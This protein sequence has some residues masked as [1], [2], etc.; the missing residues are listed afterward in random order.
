MHSL[1]WLLLA[2][3]SYSLVRLGFLRDFQKT[4]QRLGISERRAFEIY[5][6]FMFPGVL[7][8]ES[9]HWITAKALRI[10]TGSVSLRPQH[11]PK[12]ISRL[13]YVEVSM[14]DPIRSFLVG[15]APLVIGLSVIYL[16][17]EYG[18]GISEGVSLFQ[19]HHTS[20][21]A[22]WLTTRI[23]DPWVWC[24][25]YLILVISNSM[26]PSEADRRSWKTVFLGFLFLGLILSILNMT[27]VIAEWITPFF[28]RLTRNL[29]GIFAILAVVNGV[30]WALFALFHG[31]L[32]L[33]RRG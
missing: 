12:G 33:L 32:V 4:L 16:L 3:F 7:L 8:H 6:L 9:S 24:S 30:G 21:V 22:D 11:N 28:L 5:A 10:P 31:G 27:A 23:A 1:I 29:T 26:L 18:I 20:R 17:A 19:H 15:I 14:T 2:I 13:G 25:F